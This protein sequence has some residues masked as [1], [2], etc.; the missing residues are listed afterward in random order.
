MP[1]DGA[2]LST[3]EIKVFTKE[4]LKLDDSGNTTYI[5]K[6]LFN[7]KLNKA[8]DPIPFRILPDNID[9]IAKSF[10]GRPYVYNPANS[11]THIRGP[12]DDPQKIIEY[13]KKFALGLIAETIKKPN[14]N[15]YG[16]IEIL[17]EYKDDVLSG[18]IPLPTSPLLEPLKWDGKNILEAR[19]IHLQAVKDSGY[20]MEL[21]SQ[22]GVC[23]GM[24]N[25]CT[26]ELKTLGASGKLK[27]FQNTFLNTSRTIGSSLSNPENQG[28]MS[29]EEMLKSHD[30]A[31][32]AHGKMLEDHG[33]TLGSMSDKLDQVLKQTSGDPGDNYNAGEQNPE[34]AA[35]PK[36]TGAAGQKNISFEEFE[37]LKK[38]FADLKSL[39]AK[40]QEDIKAREEKRLAK[41]RENLANV[42]VD[43]EIM[44]KEI[45]E[46]EAD[47][48]L[49]YYIDLKDEDTKL[50][51]DLKLLAA[52][53]AK[54][55]KTVGSSK[56]GK[57]IA[58]LAEEFP[59][60][61]TPTVGASSTSKTSTAD[62]MKEIGN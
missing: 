5:L 46:D 1:K 41:E 12:K 58:D 56:V 14:N 55:I 37:Q 20:P 30:E 16:I 15:V 57:T 32:K 50:P 10:I 60:L 13:Q 28:A 24:L 11:T 45:K 36:T 44:N 3:D 4:G 52:K 27:N 43:S 33:K 39:R 53:A 21:T 38:D 48:R 35:K 51:V 31:I 47:K 29:P 40:E 26:Q 49:K 6:F 7:D 54:Q 59:T 42:I 34:G 2:P 17:P 62:I 18:K 23:E 9:N 8:A 61:D 19:G 22:L 25:K